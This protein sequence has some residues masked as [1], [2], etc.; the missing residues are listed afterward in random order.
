MGLICEKCKKLHLI[1]SR[2]K[3]RR[4]RYDNRRGEFK[5]AGPC[6]EITYFQ[7]GMLKPYSD[8]SGQLAA[9]REIPVNVNINLKPAESIRFVTCPMVRAYEGH[10]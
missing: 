1:S 7:K 3:L 5:L 8:E 2:D 6:S 4:I 9:L 10:A